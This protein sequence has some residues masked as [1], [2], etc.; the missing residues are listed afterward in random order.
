MQTAVRFGPQFAAAHNQLGYMLLQWNRLEEAEFHCRNAFTLQPDFIAAMGNLANIVQ[1]QGRL[2][3]AADL[4]RRILNIAP[5]DHTAYND[6]G[7]VYLDAMQLQLAEECFLKAV[8]LN[9]QHFLAY[10]NLGN[11]YVLQE[12][13]ERAVDALRKAIELKPDLHRATMQLVNQLQILCRWDDLESLSQRLID[14]VDADAEQHF[15]APFSFVGLPI[16]TTAEQ[17]L[18]CARN[19]GRNF[20]VQSEGGSSKP[21][22]STSFAGCVPSPIDGKIRVGYLSA[23]FRKHAVGYMLPELFEKHDRSAFEVYGYSLSSDDGTT[24]RRRI[25]ESCDV[26]RNF[27]K[28]SHRE[29]ACQIAADGIHI[30]VDLQGYTGHSRPDILAMRPAPVQVSYIGYPGS[31][32]V[33]FID[34]ILADEYVLPLDQQPYYTETIVQL[35]GCYQVN[36]SRHEIAD[37]RPTRR[38]C[39]LPEDAIVFCSFNTSYK[40]T[41][42]MFDVWMNLLRR[43]PGSVL[44]LAE[45]YPTIRDTL[46]REAAKRDVDP[47]RLVFAKIIPIA[48][49]LARQPLADIFL[50]SFPYNAHATASIA[51]RMGVPLVT[52]SGETLSSRVAGS[53]LRAVGLESLITGSF[54]EYEAL[55]FRLATNR[56]ELRDVRSLL[57]ENLKTTHLFDGGWFVRNLENAYRKMLG[58]ES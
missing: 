36:D 30:L 44:W 24:V 35:P 37:Y 14:V 16:P 54:E 17:Q 29:A 13:F 27:Q 40:Y 50:D 58:V 1:L 45:K 53:L 31:M 22:T 23:D 51:L 48:D 46:S 21:K 28:L 10:C 39:D 43:V 4:Y 32:G 9:S 6:L 5:D 8:E 57:A 12:D 49:H 7:A 20:S 41:P 3:E 15:I 55:T 33:D 18:K 56:D 2:S 52:L 11:C 34:Y 26:F 47:A 25:E 38:E 42:R 19:W